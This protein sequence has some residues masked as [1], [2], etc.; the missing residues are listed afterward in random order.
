MA[1]MRALG[2][3]SNVLVQSSAS[4]TIVAAG[5][6]VASM[7]NCSG[8]ELIAYCATANG[9]TVTVT[10]GST[11]AVGTAYTT[12][13]GFGQPSIMYTQ[14]QGV[15]VSSRPG[16]NSWV[17][18]TTAWS[19]NALPVGGS[20][21]VTV[22]DF[23]VSELADQYDYLGFSGSPGMQL[24]AIQYDLTVQRTPPNLANAGS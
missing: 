1:G 13:N 11:N 4:G 3:V 15:T 12:A 19:S 17:K 21:T 7:K 9:G 22:V 6:I 23:L 14:A 24:T 5:T 2:R 16:T 8:I 10:A 20:G 18:Q